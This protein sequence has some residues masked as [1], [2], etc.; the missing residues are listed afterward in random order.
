MPEAWDA[1]TPLKEKSVVFV[2]VPEEK[3]YSRHY[4][5]VESL[6]EYLMNLVEDLDLRCLLPGREVKEGESWKIELS[7]IV[8][9]FTPGGN[10]PMQYVKGGNTGLTTAV[11]AGVGG[12]LFPVFAGTVK[13][14]CTATWS[15]TQPSE[16]G[17]LAAIEL[18]LDID[19]EAD[20]TEIA[21]RMMRQDEDDAQSPVR[22]AGV[23]WKFTGSG[24]L[25]WNLDAGRFE[26]LDLG[27][28][29]EVT[30]DIQFARGEETASQLLSMAGGLKISAS[31]VPP[32]K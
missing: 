20:R 27:G 5:Q 14:N 31:V 25:L 23:R 12:S 3:D 10:I 16:G 13:G 6:E 7:S 29:E 30:S 9:L 11:A 18:A 21:R 19:T 2:W 28:K 32:K 17:R 24:T 8:N 22:H 1:D 4:D 26:K 15:K